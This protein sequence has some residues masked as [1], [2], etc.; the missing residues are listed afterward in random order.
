MLQHIN[1][2][3]FVTN[4]PVFKNVNQLN[5]KILTTMTQRRHKVHKTQDDNM[6]LNNNTLCSSWFFI[7][8]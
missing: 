8:S 4:Q 1:I 3:Y 7:V 5:Y 6:I 2:K